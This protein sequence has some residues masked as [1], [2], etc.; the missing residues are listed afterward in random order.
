MLFGRVD[1]RAVRRPI[2]VWVAIVWIVWI[3]IV[4]G[5]IEVE[6]E[7]MTEAMVMASSPSLC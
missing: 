6:T 5:P 3:A 7:R 1:V 4:R 2:V